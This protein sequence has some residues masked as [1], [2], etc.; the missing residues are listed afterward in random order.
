TLRLGTQ[1]ER[2]RGLADLH[3]V[4]GLGVGRRREHGLDGGCLIRLR[5]DVDRRRVP[6]ETEIT[7]GGG[8]ADEDGAVDLG[9]ERRRR[10]DAGEVEPLP[11]E[12]DAL[13]RVE[14]IDSE[15]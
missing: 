10:E 8:E 6:V 7:L 2:E 15:S 12:P 14:A 9:G 3:L 1:G 13:A 5:A 4:R 11:S